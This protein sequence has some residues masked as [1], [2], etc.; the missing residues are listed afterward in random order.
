ME[1]Q[2]K[3][4]GKIIVISIAIVLVA[5]IVFLIHDS[6]VKK[7]KLDN[8]IVGLYMIAPDVQ[9]HDD[10]AYLAFDSNGNYTYYK[11]NLVSWEGKYKKGNSEDRI[12]KFKNKD[13]KEAG[14]AVLYGDKLYFAKEGSAEH[15]IFTKTDD[16][17]T[18]INVPK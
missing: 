8:N 14:E 9:F 18:Y 7:K 4:K 12:Y 3:S 5:V 1:K 15:I 6:G 16:V 11:Q 13:G 2:E 17:P 10:N